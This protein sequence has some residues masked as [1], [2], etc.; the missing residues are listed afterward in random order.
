MGASTNVGNVTLANGVTVNFTGTNGSFATNGA[1]RTFN[2][3][4]GSVL[5]FSTLNFSTAAGVGFVKTGSGV[6]ALAGATYAGGFT[7]SAGT[8]IARGVNAMGGG[9][10]N[11][12]TLNGGTLAS[13][14]SR[15][16]DAT[17]FGGGIV[18]GG[19]TQFG[20]LATNVSIASSTAN[21]S[22]ANN[23]S[24]GGATR[25]LT[26]GNN[27]TQTFSGI[28]SGSAGAGV[29]VEA[30]NGVTGSMI[31]TGAN[32]YS[33]PTSVNAGTLNISG[34]GSLTNTSAVSISGGTLLLSGTAANR[35]NNAAGVSL[36]GTGTTSRLQTTGA[37]TES[38][39]SL[40]I[41]GTGSRVID[42]GTD[43]SG[44]KLTFSG[45]V[46]TQTLSI[47]NWTGSVLTTGGLDR[48]L[49]SAGVD[50]ASYT[51]VNFYSDAAG[52]VPVGSGAQLFDVGGGN[53]ELVPVPEARAVFGVLALLAPLAYR[54]RRHWMRCREARIC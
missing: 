48:V 22:F 1:V 4:T 32:T 38:F 11:V 49:F 41:S 10:T 47:W 50:G 7:L 24:L 19:N 29:T 43:A 8:V 17:K 25:T 34:T 3:G 30:A 14:N 20:E 15:A 28:I 52:L 51:N 9:A 45:A 42:Y 18:I 13:N 54:E 35:I 31:F 6:L 53:F 5:D 23:V 36:E 21:L 46:P 40:T 2:I 39:G 16:F 44:S 12:L 33:G 26:I 27:G 37:V